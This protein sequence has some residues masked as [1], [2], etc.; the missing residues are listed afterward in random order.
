MKFFRPYRFATAL[1]AL[2]GMLFMQLAVAAYVCPEYQMGQA[3]QAD[4]PMTMSVVA[5]AQDMSGCKGMDSEQPGLCDAH[6]RSGAQSLDK[7]ELP[8]VQSFPVVGKALAMRPVEAGY[9][10]PAAPSQF[11]LL[12]LLLTRSTAPPLVVRNCCFRI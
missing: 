8:Q 5:I 1:I 10:A 9:R 3:G 2:F 11:L 7:P 6:D 4:G 12:S